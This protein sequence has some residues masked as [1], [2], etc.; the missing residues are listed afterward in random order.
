MN[1]LSAC[2]I[3]SIVFS[4]F[5]S[6]AQID[7]GVKTEIYTSVDTFFTKGVEAALSD[8]H[9][10]KIAD[11]TFLVSLFNPIFGLIP[12]MSGIAKDP[13]LNKSYL[14]PQLPQEYHQGFLHQAKLIRKKKVIKNW[15]QGSAINLGF[16][17]VFTIVL[18]ST[19]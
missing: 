5:I 6:K 3:L 8:Y 7:D 11:V 14:G 2:L 10:D 19:F 1:F 15:L 13:H 18:A 16:T 9:P 17:V 4:A 12:V